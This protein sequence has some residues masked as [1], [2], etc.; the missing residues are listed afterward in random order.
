M[1]TLTTAGFIV[2]VAKCGFFQTEVMFV[3]HKID[4]TEVSADPARMEAIFKYQASQNLK[5]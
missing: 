3:G 1:R 4:R 5:Q 2:T